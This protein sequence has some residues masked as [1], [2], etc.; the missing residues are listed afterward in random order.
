M[1]ARSIADTVTLNNA[2]RM[3]ILGLGVWKMH[4]GDETEQAVRAALK[5]G[6]RHIDT[7][8]L[9]G[10]EASV[11]RAVRA[12][13]IPREELFVTTKLWPTDFFTPQK[14]FEESLERLG[15]EYV[16]LYLI[17]WPIPF[18]PKS[19]WMALEDIYAKKLARSIGVSN[20]DIKDIEK[21]LA[22]A[23]VVPAIN[24]VKF[25]PFDHEKE[26]L[27]Y[28]REKHVA[29]EAYSPLTRGARFDDPTLTRIAKKYQKS[30]AQILIRWCIEHEVIV[31]PKS[32]DP[33]RI[34]EN[35]DVFDFELAEEDLHALDSLG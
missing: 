34:S 25:S 21:L 16:D 7:A 26:L 6:Y 24:Q 22:Y 9:Y 18:M 29:L 32:S 15:F 10:N 1:N 31:I 8:T 27:A 4:D 23:T 30:P 28:C 19:V 13:R 35:A 12:S 20:Y 11:G 5:V 3:P 14:A 33:G 2:V 17:H